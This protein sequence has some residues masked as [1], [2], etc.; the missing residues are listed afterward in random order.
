MNAHQ[1]VLVLFAVVLGGVIAIAFVT[2]FHRIHTQ[3]VMSARRQV[4]S[5]LQ[6]RNDRIDKP[7]YGCVTSQPNGAGLR[8]RAEAIR[9]SELVWAIIC[10][11]GVSRTK[12]AY[13]G[14]PVDVQAPAGILFQAK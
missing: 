3:Q 7:R 2:T 5:G 6:S 14:G 10:S 11:C 12:K 13:K 4:R 9:I 8:S 1:T